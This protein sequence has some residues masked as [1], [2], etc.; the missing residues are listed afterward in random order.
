MEVYGR[1]TNLNNGNLEGYK[2]VVEQ[3]HHP[4]PRGT[5]PP[6]PKRPSAPP[7][8][9]LEIRKPYIPDGLILIRML[10]NALESIIETV[11]GSEYGKYG[12]SRYNRCRYGA[13]LGIYG[14]DYYD[15]CRYG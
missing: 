3:R 8:V 15:S 10:S 9:E 13:R 12:R 6:R 5:Q 4:W 7:F 2:M 1:P 14:Y 11:T